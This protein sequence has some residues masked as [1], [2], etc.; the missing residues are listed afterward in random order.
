MQ[1]F[2]GIYEMAVTEANLQISY[3]ITLLGQIEKMREE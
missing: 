2:E 3:Q 1:E